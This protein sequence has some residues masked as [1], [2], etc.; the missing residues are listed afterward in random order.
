VT[1]QGVVAEFLRR[2]PGPDGLFC[3]GA[4][5]TAQPWTAVMPFTLK[6]FRGGSD[7]RI[8]APYFEKGMASPRADYLICIEDGKVIG[9]CLAEDLRTNYVRYGELWVLPA[10]LPPYAA[11]IFFH[12]CDVCGDPR[13]SLGVGFSTRAGVMGQLYCRNHSTDGTGLMQ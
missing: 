2:E 6:D 1:D 8:V 13:P 12:G 11:Y 3:N 4:G 7:M 9:M 10:I 5:D